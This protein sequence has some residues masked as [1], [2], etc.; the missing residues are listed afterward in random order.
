MQKT[1]EPFCHSTDIAIFIP[2]KSKDLGR[3]DQKPK[4]ARFI[5]LLGMAWEV[6]AEVI[7]LGAREAANAREDLG[8]ERRRIK[9][10]YLQELIVGIAGKDVMTFRS[11][12]NSAS[13]HCFP[14]LGMTPFI[15]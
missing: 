5:G 15:S 4:I 9:M 2:I 13:M 6:G 3:T 12:I 10:G 14:M 7:I 1:H 11:L 8:I